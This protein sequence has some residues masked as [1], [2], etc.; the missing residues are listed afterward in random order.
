VDVGLLSA[1][2][3][4]RLYPKDFDP[5]KLRPLLMHPPTLAAIKA[6]KPLKE[7]RAAWQKDLD[8]FMLRRA[9]Y[10]MY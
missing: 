3:L 10:L 5:E 8:G 6:A 7:I 9:K 4:F 2:T 1:E